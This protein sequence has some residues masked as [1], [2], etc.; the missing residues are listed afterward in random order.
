[1]LSHETMEKLRRVNSTAVVDT[2]ARNGYAPHY[3][4]MSSIKNLTPGQRLVG[5]AVTV[6]FVPARPDAAAEKPPRE[7]SPE[8]A[9]F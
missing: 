5:R 6:R 4:Y 8:Y 7:Q 2:L 3:V 9:A 1:M